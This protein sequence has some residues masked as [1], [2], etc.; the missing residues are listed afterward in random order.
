VR[1]VSPRKVAAQYGLGNHV[2]V[3]RHAR[4]HLPKATAP[5]APAAQG[6]GDDLLAE[7]EA[8][9]AQQQRILDKAEADKDYRGAISAGR[10]LLRCVELSAKLRG[11][12]ATGP[13]I[14]IVASPG[15]QQLVALMLEYSDPFRRVEMAERLA[16]LAPT[17]GAEPEAIDHVAEQ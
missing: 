4:D 6:S 11:E 7:V 12:L 8:I 3:W 1:G 14:N 5:A 16:L 2:L 10:E 17:H 9:A 15:F 13:T